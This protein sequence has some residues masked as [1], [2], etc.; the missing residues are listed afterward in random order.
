MTSAAVLQVASTP[1]KVKDMKATTS[2]YVGF[3]AIVLGFMAVLQK[4]GLLGNGSAPTTICTGCN[5]YGR[6]ICHLCKGSGTI[7]WEGKL[8]RTDVCPS[9]L[10]NLVKK[11]S[12]C[13]GYRMRTDDPP[14]LQQ[15]AELKASRT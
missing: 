1:L 14:F 2:F 9:C 11:C 8:K 10:G 7:S 5:G 15:L 6:R 4:G 13:G 3:T 12:D